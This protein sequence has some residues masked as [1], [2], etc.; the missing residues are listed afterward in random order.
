M[1]G[2]GHFPAEHL[3]AA[4]DNRLAHQIRHINIGNHVG[5]IL[6]GQRLVAGS[7]LGF[8]ADGNQPVQVALDE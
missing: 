5:D 1:A 7:F 4:L 6:G 8:L 2:G 3:R